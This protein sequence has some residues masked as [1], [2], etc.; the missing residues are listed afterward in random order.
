MVAFLRYIGTLM[1][2]K[3]AF[4]FLAGWMFLSILDSIMPLTA[5]SSIGNQ[6]EQIEPETKRYFYG[7]ASGGSDI[8]SLENFSDYLDNVSNSQ[9][10]IT[11]IEYPAWSG[12]GMMGYRENGFNLNIFYE[13]LARKKEESYNYESRN[14][15]Y[16]AG[17]FSS[18]E[19][20][21]Y[22]DV[23]LSMNAEYYLMRDKAVY[24]KKSV[25]NSSTEIFDESS[26]MK[27]KSNGIR[28]STGVIYTPKN[29]RFDLFIGPTW[30]HNQTL[31]TEGWEENYFAKAAWL[32][33]LGFKKN[34]LWIAPYG[35]LEKDYFMQ[36]EAIGAFF[37]W[38]NHLTFD[39]SVGTQFSSVEVDYQFLPFAN[40]FIALNHE[41]QFNN[42]FIS[43][44]IRIRFSGMGMPDMQ[45]E[46]VF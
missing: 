13:G 40:A 33:R 41:D 26:T 42:I 37:F 27:S 39:L 16:R 28:Q 1:R 10:E 11:S 35:S 46:E 45:Q 6:Y 38:D 4:I 43:A 29:F 18:Y 8:Y 25:I 32:T 14:T 15:R 22:K 19:Y 30:R 23:L 21:F 5:K 36:N 34:A 17:F 7:S 31:D 3:V 2:P 9:Y 12:N 24:G 44:G 20:L